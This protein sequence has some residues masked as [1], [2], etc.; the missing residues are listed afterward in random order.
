MIPSSLERMTVTGR[1]R[2][3][4][5]SVMAARNPALPPPSTITRLTMSRLGPA[6]HLPQRRH[7]RRAPPS[8]L[9]L[10]LLR[11]VA[12]AARPRL[13]ARFVAALAAAVGVAD[14]LQREEL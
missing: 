1:S 7:E 2:S 5:R 3:R 11:A 12:V 14:A 4:V 10:Q 6:D 13:L 8:H 9:P